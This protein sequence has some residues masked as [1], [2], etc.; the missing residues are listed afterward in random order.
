[1]ELAIIFNFAFLLYVIFTYK[2]ILRSKTHDISFD[3]CNCLKGLI[4]ISVV[5][6][7]ISQGRDI[8]I[9]GELFRPFGSVAVGCFFFISGYGLYVSYSKKQ[10]YLDGF[11]LKR[12]RKLIVPFVFVIFLYQLVNQGSYERIFSG[13]AVGNPDYLLPHSWYIFCAILFYFAFYYIFKYMSDE[14]IKI[15]SVF[16][17]TLIFYIF[18]RFILKWPGFWSGSLFL[19]P[20]GIVFKYIERVLIKQ[21]I[22]YMIMSSMFITVLVIML[23]LTDIKYIGIVK[24]CFSSLAIILP[25]TVFNLSSKYLIFLGSIS[26]EVYLVQGIIFY[27]L[28][29]SAIDN[30]VLFAFI[31]VTFVIILAYIVKHLLDYIDKK[32]FRLVN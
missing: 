6:H 20:I 25:F 27:I 13:L 8:F 26:Y 19:F 22:S 4:A 15:I 2:S 18:L 28:E 12:F 16:I 1:M 14:K 11:L 21:P 9:L 24:I 29:K 3:S 5:L 7:H 32:L 23:Y 10:S 30:N 17:F 31:S